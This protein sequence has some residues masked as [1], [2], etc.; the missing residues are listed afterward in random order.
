MRGPAKVVAGAAYL[1]AVL[2][3]CSGCG[4]AGSDA[5]PSARRSSTVHG[6]R[7]IGSVDTMKLSKDRADNL[8]VGEI[9]RV[10]DLLA[11]SL[12]TTHVTVD[13]PLERPSVIGTWANRIHSDHKRVWFRLN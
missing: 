4:V 13:V 7:F 2:A 9:D 1:A 11:R 10:V 6:V 5:S 12:S 3:I 8:S